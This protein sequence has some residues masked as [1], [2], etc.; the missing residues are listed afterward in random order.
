MSLRAAAFA[1]WW[2]SNLLLKRNI[3]KNRGLLRPDKSIRDGVGKSKCPPH[4]D[5]CTVEKIYRK[6]RE[7]RKELSGSSR[8]L[9]FKNCVT[10]SHTKTGNSP[11]LGASNQ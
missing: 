1:L 2:R 11:I 3:A 8:A 9:R 10:L 7:V 5:I 4:N 6:A